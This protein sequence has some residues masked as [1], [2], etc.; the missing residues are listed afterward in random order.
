MIPNCPLPG[1]GRPLDWAPV[2]VTMPDGERRE[3]WD[4]AECSCGLRLEYD[5]N[6]PHLRQLRENARLDREEAE[7]DS[8]QMDLLTVTQEG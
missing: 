8:G 3:V 1:C 5:P 4:A 6:Q 2:H 7:K